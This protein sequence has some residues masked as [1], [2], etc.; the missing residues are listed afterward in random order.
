MHAFKHFAYN[1]IPLSTKSE[2]HHLENPK[3]IFEILI[4]GFFI[5][6]LVKEN[7]INY[8]SKLFLDNKKHYLFIFRCK[9]QEKVFFI[10]T[11]IYKRR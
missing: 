6:E 5:M 2:N 4:R 9:T 3:D 10:K 1:A 11:I 8:H 7:D